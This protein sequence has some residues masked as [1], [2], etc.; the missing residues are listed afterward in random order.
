M[1]SL[2]FNFLM[3]ISADAGTIFIPTEGGLGNCERPDS[4]ASVF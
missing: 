2:A 1:A 4:N 3:A